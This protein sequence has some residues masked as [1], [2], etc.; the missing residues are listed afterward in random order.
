[1][2]DEW[3]ISP[4]LF[5][6]IRANL[7]KGKTILELGSGRG[8]VELLKYYNVYSV[9]HNPDWIGYAKKGNYIYAPIVEYD[10]CRWYDISKLILPEDY[11]LILV[12]GPTGSIG[13]EGF[14]INRHLFNLN[15][16]IIIDD[17]QRQPEKHMAET[18]SMILPPHRKP[19]E[20]HFAQGRGFT[21]L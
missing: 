12:D 15:V 20:S 17:V 8:T 10:K 1:M 2:F 16:P 5:S 21:I 3:S 9:E 19:M 7:P 6:W 18:L 4:E 11:D 14:L 13:R